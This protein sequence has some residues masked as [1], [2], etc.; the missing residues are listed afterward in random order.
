M[1]KGWQMTSWCTAHDVICE[2]KM[3]E[4]DVV[5]IVTGVCEETFDINDKNSSNKAKYLKF[6][7]QK[8][9]TTRNGKLTWLSG[10]FQTLYLETRRNGL[11]S[12]VSQIMRENWQSCGENSWHF[13]MLPLW[14][15]WVVTAEIPYW[16]HVTTQILVVTRHQYGISVLISQMSFFRET[17]VVALQNVNCFLRLL[18]LKSIQSLFKKTLGRFGS[19]TVLPKRFHFNTHYTGLHPQDSLKKEKLLRCRLL[20]PWIEVI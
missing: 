5:G 20:F 3:R 18:T 6:H 13:I 7:C 2:K 4:K 11:K 1:G 17:T 10:R 16:W 8:V 12:G 9:E 14:F 15:P 19:Y